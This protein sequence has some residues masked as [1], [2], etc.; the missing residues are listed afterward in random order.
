MQVATEY[1]AA[2]GRRGR[3]SGS[4]ASKCLWLTASV[5]YLYGA[6][7][8]TVST[9]RGRIFSGGEGHL[10]DLRAIFT[11]SVRLPINRDLHQDCR[12]KVDGGKGIFAQ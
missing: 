5:A 12:Y 4:M 11:P 6:R 3:P 8:R 9:N 10:D 1:Q 7:I 2:S